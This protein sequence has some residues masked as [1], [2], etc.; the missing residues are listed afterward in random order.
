[1]HVKSV[2]Y[3]TT[4]RKGRSDKNTKRFPVVFYLDDDNSF[5]SKRIKW[6]EVSYYKRKIKKQV[7]IFCTECQKKFDVLVMKNEV[8]LCPQCLS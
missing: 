8:A 7:R 6:Y 5:H 3:V 4:N 1:M 2:S